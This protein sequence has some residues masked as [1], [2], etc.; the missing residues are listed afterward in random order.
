MDMSNYNAELYSG[1]E[2]YAMPQTV[3]EKV[4]EKNYGIV[5]KVQY[6][7]STTD[8]D[9]NLIVILPPG[10]EENGS[11]SYPVLYLFHGLGQDERMWYEDGKADVIL[12]NMLSDK[13]ASEMILVMPNCRAVH[14][15]RC[16]VPEFQ[17]SNYLAF[18]NFIDD[19]VKNVM[20]FVQKNYRIKTGRENTAIAGLSQGGRVALHIGFTYPELFGYIGSFT[21]APGILPYSNFFGSEPGLFSEDTLKFPE[22]FSDNT[23]LMLTAGKYDNLVGGFPESYHVVLENNRVKHLYYVLSTGHDWN[24]WDN[25]LYQFL[26]RIFKNK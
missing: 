14:D 17:L 23:F 9:R 7:S 15:D 6:Y 13:T 5:K 12:G 20:P 19:M 24:I 1:D 18:N 16:P 25:S 11:E 4:A 21:P 2:L 8:N 3:M 26:K 22:K 10:Y